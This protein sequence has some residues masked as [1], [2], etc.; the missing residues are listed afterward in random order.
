MED[1]NSRNNIGVEFERRYRNMKCAVNY[2]NVSFHVLP[3][4]P[5]PVSGARLEHLPFGIPPCEIRD[6]WTIEVNDMSDLTALLSGGEVHLVLSEGPFWSGQEI[7]NPGEKLIG[8][9][10]LDETNP[11]I[12]RRG[13]SIRFLKR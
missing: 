9:G 11:Q 8:I 2:Y 1:E 3:D 7:E 10:V 6:I 12:D 13:R 4:E 5:P